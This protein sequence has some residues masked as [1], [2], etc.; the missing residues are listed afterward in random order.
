MQCNDAA[1]LSCEQSAQSH[2]FVAVKQYILHIAMIAATVNN[3]NLLARLST[4]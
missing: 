3:T 2:I 1:A 4:T